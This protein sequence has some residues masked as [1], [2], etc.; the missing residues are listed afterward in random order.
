MEGVKN[1]IKREIYYNEGSIDKEN[2]TTDL[3]FIYHVD[4]NTWS[5]Q[6]GVG[7]IADG[8][9]TL[10]IASLLVKFRELENKIKGG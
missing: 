7:V 3:Y 5:V 9:L 2:I 1:L 4:R 10:L 6:D 8:P